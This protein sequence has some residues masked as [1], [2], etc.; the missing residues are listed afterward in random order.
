MARNDRQLN[1]RI[2]EDLKVWIEAQSSCNGSSQT[3]EVIRALRE[4]MQRVEAEAAHEQ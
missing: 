3:S 2:P 4:R 1:L